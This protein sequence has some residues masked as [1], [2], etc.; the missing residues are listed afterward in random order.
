MDEKNLQ[1]EKKRERKAAI[2]RIFARSSGRFRE[3]TGSDEASGEEESSKAKST[4]GVED[5]TDASSPVDVEVNTTDAVPKVPTAFLESRTEVGAAADAL[6]P[7]SGPSPERAVDRADPQ[8][9]PT[10]TG[11]SERGSVCSSVSP[12]PRSSC[13]S[14]AVSDTV[15]AYCTASE[16]G[17][18]S[19]RVSKSSSGFLGF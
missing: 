19:S 12:R 5:T 6:S 18:Y 2:A 8:P 16:G 3:S 1:A 10:T 17:A 15:S 9:S 4:T 14:S 13:F 7:E 11:V